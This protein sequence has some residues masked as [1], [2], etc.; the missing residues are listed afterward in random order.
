[1]KPEVGVSGIIGEENYHI[2]FFSGIAD[3]GINE[4]SEKME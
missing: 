4:N 1:L 2:G 3:N